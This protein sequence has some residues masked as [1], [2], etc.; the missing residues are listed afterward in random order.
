M[1]EKAGRKVG[2][3]NQGAAENG[4]AFGDM[5]VLGERQL[6][7]GCEN[8]FSLQVRAEAEGSG[9][10]WGLDLGSGSGSD[11]LVR[12]EELLRVS[13]KDAQPGAWGCLHNSP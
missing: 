5:T 4:K 9:L 2:S 1:G 13:V 12:S 7:P 6:K 11:D 3:S 8:F 10:A